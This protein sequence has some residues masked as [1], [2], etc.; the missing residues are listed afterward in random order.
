[1]D[2]RHEHR[3][4]QKED[5]MK[6]QGKDGHLPAKERRPQKKSTLPNTLILDFL[7]PEL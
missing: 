3:H 6:T 1:M 2:T 5:P 7:P 4:T